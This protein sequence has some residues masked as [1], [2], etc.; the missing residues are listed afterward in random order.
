MSKVILLSRNKVSRFEYKNSIEERGEF[1]FETKR[2]LGIY[3]II[4]KGNKFYSVGIKEFI[5]DTVG[6]DEIK[7]EINPGKTIESDFTC[8]YCKNID[9][10]VL[11]KSE[12]EIYCGN[13]GSTVNLNYDDGNFIA[14]PVFPSSIIIVK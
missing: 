10:D 5:T 1:I 4:K 14:E 13:C 6:V 7:F 3:D 11:E 9:Y 12:G 2:E 8:P